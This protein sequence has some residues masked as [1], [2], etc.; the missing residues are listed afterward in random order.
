MTNSRR[1]EFAQMMEEDDWRGV[2]EVFQVFQ[3]NNF[4]K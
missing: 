4:M 3:S 2:I 1:H